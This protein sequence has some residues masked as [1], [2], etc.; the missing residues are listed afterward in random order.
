MK[1]KM[2]FKTPAIFF[3]VLYIFSLI[4]GVVN[5]N[6][7]TLL[8]SNVYAQTNI[9]IK[10]LPDFSK[11]S[12]VNEKKEAFFSTL[13]PIIQAE[14]NHVLQLRKLI[15]MLKDI[16][17]KKLSAKQQAWL[18]SVSKKYKLEN[19]YINNNIFEELLKR[20]DY[21]PPS[22]ALTQAAIESGWGSSRFA[23]QGNNLFGQWCFSSGCGMV[24]S[25][26][27]SGKGHEVAK[28]DT[29]NLAVRSYILNL[30][31][32]ESYTELR[33]NRADLRDKELSFTGIALAKALADYSEE[34]SL[35]VVKL[36]DF[37]HQNK[38]QRFTIAFENTVALSNE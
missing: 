23:R 33:E 14:N 24:P 19:Q 11:I 2:K 10:K 4:T 5:G 35:Y 8:L 18:L 16:P 36:T 38:L 30:N 17:V 7:S 21:V 29:V 12:N 15:V 26:R 3:S 6:N 31:S 32:H 37:I 27:E 9:G 28:F 34:G 1:R 13:Y 25:L 20:V 22:L